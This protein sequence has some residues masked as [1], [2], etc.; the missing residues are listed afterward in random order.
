[1]FG[2]RALR[3][4]IL[5]SGWSGRPPPTASRFVGMATLASMSDHPARFKISVCSPEAEADGMKPSA[6]SAKL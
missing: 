6:P 2:V 1:M 3:S 5:R 4:R